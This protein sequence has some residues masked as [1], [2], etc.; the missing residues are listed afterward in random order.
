M[1]VLTDHTVSSSHGV[2]VVV[3]G[4]EAEAE[5]ERFLTLE[6]GSWS[7]EAG[8]PSD[9]L[10]PKEAR[11]PGGWH[12]GVRGGGAGRVQG[13]PR[14]QHIS[15]LLKVNSSSLFMFMYKSVKVATV[16]NMNIK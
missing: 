5:A 3:S 2:T 16:L 10:M 6:A 11:G 4:A 7:L 13:P 15:D 8:L 14:P 9:S 1:M 12:R